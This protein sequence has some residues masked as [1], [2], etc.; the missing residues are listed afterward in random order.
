MVSTVFK[1]VVCVLW[2]RTSV[3]SCSCSC[4]FRAVFRLRLCSHL[5]SR[6]LASAPLFV[7][8]PPSHVMITVAQ[9][10][11]YLH[12]RSPGIA[13]S[14]ASNATVF[15]F[16]LS[17]FGAGTSFPA[18]LQQLADVVGVFVRDRRLL[19]HCSSVRS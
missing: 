9:L 8:R 14:A 11:P 18:S 7:P 2:V 15:V 6:F 16:V 4:S 19:A 10:T 5:R 17:R 3:S 13:S 1:V 12:R